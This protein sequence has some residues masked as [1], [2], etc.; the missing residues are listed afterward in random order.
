[1]ECPLIREKTVCKYS[2]AF[3]KVC[4]EPLNSIK[5]QDQGRLVACGSH[6]GTTTL[7]ELSDSLCTLLRHEKSTINGVRNLYDFSNRYTVRK[8][9]EVRYRFGALNF[10]KIFYYL[11]ALEP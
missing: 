9:R 10:C 2:S 3:L 4:D 1:M 6:Q 11:Y 5:V 8:N 7:I